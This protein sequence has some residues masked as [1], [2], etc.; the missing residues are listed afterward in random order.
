MKRTEMTLSDIKESALGCLCELVSF[1]RQNKIQYFLS[2]GT[3]L[4][5]VKYGGFIPWDDDIDVFI[6]REDYNRLVKT[7]IDSEKYALYAIERNRKYLFPFA[8][9]CD[10]STEKIEYNIYNGVELGVD[11]DIFPLDNLGDT[12]EDATKLIDIQKRLIT[13]QMFHKCKNAD[14][15]NYMKRLAKNIILTLSRPLCYYYTKRL[16][17]NAKKYAS[18]QMTSYVG[19]ASWCIYGHQ[20]ILPQELFSTTAEKIFQN[21]NFSIPIGYDA[22]LKSL[23]GDYE[24]DYPLD[25]CVSHH[26]FKAYFK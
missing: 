24:M 13:K 19:C 23:Y 20:E 6:P 15:R 8:K 7:Y 5:A 21:I 10:V 3:L 22:Y 9:L 11:V 25:K 4:G 18:N 14:S 2:N 17:N 12:L 16:S 1:C 26:K